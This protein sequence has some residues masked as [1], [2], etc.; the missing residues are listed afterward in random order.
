MKLHHLSGPGTNGKRSLKIIKYFFVIHT[1]SAAS[2][3]R[4]DMHSVHRGRTWQYLIK[5]E[6]NIAV[7]VFDSHIKC[8]CGVFSKL[9]VARI[10]FYY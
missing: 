3:E 9:R 10:P 8:I 5:F 1:E 4:I 6:L 7:L 2:N